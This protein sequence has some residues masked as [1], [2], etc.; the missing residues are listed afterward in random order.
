M[1]GSR[2]LGAGA[3]TPQWSLNT[4][5]CLPLPQSLARTTSPHPYGRDTKHREGELPGQ[6]L[7][8][9][10]EG[11]RVCVG[12]LG[13]HRGRHVQKLPQEERGHHSWPAGKGTLW[14]CHV[15]FAGGIGKPR[16]GGGHGEVCLHWANA[17]SCD[18][19]AGR[20]G[21]QGQER[22]RE[23]EEQWG[24]GTFEEEE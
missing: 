2:V 24:A 12:V 19:M 11:S 5:V 21:G 4:H 6:G 7:V 20:R 13:A 14:P 22:Q 15:G 17:W 1:D 16:K 9:G 18:P 10:G 8:G 23:D 3:D